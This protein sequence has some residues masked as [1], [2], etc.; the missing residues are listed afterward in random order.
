MDAIYWHTTGKANMALLEK[1]LYIA[2]YME[3]NR[4]FDGVRKMREL[5]ETDLDG[6]LLLGFEMSIDLLKSENKPL[7]RFT[8][9]A[10]DFLLGE[11]TK[12]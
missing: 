4:N 3:P 11:R 8:V 6:A 10:R 7:D 5:T 1:I 2:D 9:E 12:V